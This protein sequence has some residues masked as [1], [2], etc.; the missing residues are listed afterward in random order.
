MKASVRN[1]ITIAAIVA[2]ALAGAGDAT[3]K[4][5]AH[6]ESRA[7][8]IV[9]GGAAVSPFTTPESACAEGLK[10]GNTDTAIREF[11]IQKGYR[12]FTSPAMTGR[13]PVVDQAGFGAFGKC[14]VTLPAI[15]TVNS[16]G[17]IDLAGERLAR[18]LGY[19]NKTYGVKAVDLVAHSMGGLFSQAAIRVLK[20]TGSPIKIKSLTTIG[21][22]WEGSFL[23]DYSNSTIPMADC[24]GE[25]ACEKGM[26]AFKKA[27]DSHPPGAG[28]EV[29]SRVLAGPNG[30]IESQGNTL[31]DIPV[32]LLGGDYFKNPGRSEVWP[33]DG[34]VAM[35]SA[36]A[37]HV[38]DRALPHRRCL[39]FPDTH[40]I[41]VSN[42]V[43]AD[44]SSGITWD[45][46][47]LAA[48]DRAIIGADT[49]LSSPN[50]D[51]C[52]KP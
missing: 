50:R 48:V 25:Q 12:V 21:T 14:P 43:G 51:G 27:V 46:K 15:M 22:P 11:L 5:A 13:G 38:S 9:S 33:N 31:A 17:D 10:A 4:K 39:T 26:E 7:V 49:A 37:R 36:L 18:F 16:V 1:F 30:W 35:D 34:I 32:V 28:G 29:T 47:A 20:E 42:A 41:Y 6:K 52:P 24:R 2:S 8:V 44:W 40:S 23:A 3:A 45:P 19:L